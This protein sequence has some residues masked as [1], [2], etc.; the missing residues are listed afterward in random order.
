M[1][2]LNLLDPLPL[3]QEMIR[4]PSVYPDDAGCLEVL[5]EALEPLGFDCQTI[6]AQTAE[7]RDFPNL[8][9]KLGSGGPHLC[10]LGHSDVVPP[11]DRDAWSADPFA[12]EV[13]E[14]RLMG[15]GAADMKGGIA[16]FVSSVA[17]ILDRG[18]AL[19]GSISV[20]I[21]GDEETGR[22][23]GAQALVAEA[24][25]RGEAWDWCLVG[26]PSNPDHLGQAL[27]IGR[28]GSLCG[29]LKVNGVQGHSAYPE[30]A[31]NPVPKLLRLLNSL[32]AQPLD[33][34]NERFQPSDLQITSVDVGNPVFNLIPAR[35]EARFNVRFNS[36]H[37]PQG[38]QELLLKRLSDTGLAYELD[39]EVHGE[40]YLTQEGR[41]SRALRKAV[42][43][44]TGVTPEL[45]T[46]GG[47]SDGRFF[48]DLCPVVEFGLISQSAHQVDE[49]ADLEDL[50]KLT[51]VYEQVLR[52]LLSPAP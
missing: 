19:P 32:I 25:A 42:E 37:S 7:G 36:E 31:N 43:Q 38:L 46:G 39:M 12:A 4:C 11:G 2:R 47:F 51:Q 21:A 33:Q 48:K 41:L 5:A 30:K 6:L 8:Y 22:G 44:V 52:E 23:A 14:G 16:A 24:Q 50:E 10:F 45:S 1:T 13:R 29:S 40:A 15:R 17:R 9:A 35:A 28:R 18:D 20:L 3:A 49:R 34:G 27:K 26:E